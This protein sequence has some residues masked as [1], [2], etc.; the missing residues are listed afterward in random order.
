[1]AT[2]NGHT[3]KSDGAFSPAEYAAF[4]RSRSYDFVA[5]TDHWKRTHMS[6]FTDAAFA[7]VP[8]TELDGV[9]ATAGYGRAQRR[10]LAAMPPGTT[11]PPPAKSLASGKRAHRCS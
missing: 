2:R 5:V 1:M 9:D 4:Y 3:T 7:W 11:G 8:G 10:C 6:A